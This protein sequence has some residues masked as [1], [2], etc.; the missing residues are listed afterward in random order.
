MICP[1]RSADM[2]SAFGASEEPPG[3]YAVN[4][5][6]SALKSVGLTSTRTPF[7]NFQSVT[8]TS[9]TLLLLTTFPGVGAFASSA[10]LERFSVYAVTGALLACANTA[11]RSARVGI[12]TL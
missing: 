1:D 12:L 7:D 8:F 5:T 4:R 10:S 9:A 6:S 2:K 11:T 3:L